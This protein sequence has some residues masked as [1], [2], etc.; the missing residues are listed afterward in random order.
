MLKVGVTLVGVLLLLWLVIRLLRKVKAIKLKL[1]PR[2]NLMDKLVREFKFQLDEAVG[3]DY[4]AHPHVRLADLLVIETAKGKKA[5]DIKSRIEATSTD[6]VLTERATGKIA[7]VLIL[8]HQEKLGSRQKFIREICQQSKLPFQ[9]FDVNNA[10]SEKQIRQE[11]TMLLEPTIRFED[12]P[13]HEIKVYLEPEQRRQQ[14]PVVAADQSMTTQTKPKT[15]PAD[16]LKPQQSAERNIQPPHREPVI[17]S[18]QAVYDAP[19]S[20][21]ETNEKNKEPQDLESGPQSHEQLPKQDKTAQSP[22]KEPY[23]KYPGQSDYSAPEQRQKAT[24]RQAV[25]PPHNKQD[26]EPEFD[27]SVD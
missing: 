4:E 2:K 17:A 21:T 20:L 26:D 22:H 18:K 23:K 12:N 15:R 1:N 7:C 27:L 8:I 3:D 9:I 10:Y 5:L 24:E 13:T 11:I 14:E 6:L 16:K 19:A 25:R